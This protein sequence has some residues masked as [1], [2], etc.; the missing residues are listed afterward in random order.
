MISVHFHDIPKDAPKDTPKDTPTDTP[1]DGESKLI[2][3]VVNPIAGY[4]FYESGGPTAY[5]VETP[6][7]EQKSSN[8]I[9]REVIIPVGEI[10]RQ[11]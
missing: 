3:V 2:E 1:K 4:V 9:P 11:L 10:I 5:R 6:S 8:P 7:E